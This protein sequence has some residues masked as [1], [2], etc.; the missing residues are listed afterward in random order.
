MNRKLF[1]RNLALAS[2]AIPLSSFLPETREKMI[3]IPR[4]A[5]KCL[6]NIDP[7][8][9]TGRV[10]SGSN[11]RDMVTIPEKEIYPWVIEHT[12]VVEGSEPSRW[13]TFKNS[14]HNYND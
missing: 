12:K 10:A 11:G 7:K 2:I 9:S 1:I 8:W 5:L 4:Q 6:K 3:T 14:Q 13:Y